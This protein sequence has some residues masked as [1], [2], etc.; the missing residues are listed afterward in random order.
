MQMFYDVPCVGAISN[1]KYAI[2][3]S[4]I[5]GEMTYFILPCPFEAM[6]FA[7]AHRRIYGFGHN[8][9]VNRRPWSQSI[10]DRT[11]FVDRRNEES[12]Q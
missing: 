4:R 1:P 3:G 6:S 9:S 11:R 2:D 10:L 5:R 8:L 12:E 7:R